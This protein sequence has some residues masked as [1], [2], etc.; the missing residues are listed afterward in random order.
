M[1]TTI[2]AQYESFQPLQNFSTGWMFKPNRKGG[3]SGSGQGQYLHCSHKH[4]DSLVSLFRT[5]SFVYY[6][7]RETNYIIGDTYILD[8]SKE[9]SLPHIYK[10][11]LLLK[12][13]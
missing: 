8:Y 2:T 11:F 10:V 3:L 12:N 5:S 4:V 7:C 9:K 13:K 1:P 6:I